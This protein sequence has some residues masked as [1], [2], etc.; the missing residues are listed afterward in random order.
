MAQRTWTAVDDY[1]GGLLVEEDEALVAAN[2]DA[3]AAGLP[4]HQVAPN[5]GKLL[6]LLARIRGART[7]LEIG[8]LGGYSTIWLAR[9]LPAGGRL[10]TL[11]V[12]PHCA[13]VAEANVA[14]AGLADVVDIRRGPALALLPHLTDL[15]PFDLVFIDAD[16]PSNPDY[17]KWALE[18]TGPGSVIIGDNVVRDGAVVDPDSTDPRVQ[19]VRRFTELIAEHP[20]LT[21]TALQTVGSKG[22][23]GLVMALVTG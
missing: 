12:D 20:N 4:A 15:A 17:L 21:A 7:V 23:D 3:E 22:Y 13:D 19:G 18:L 2:A 10:V 11:E 16:K 9:A 8:T 14:R 5:Q 1:F 6:H